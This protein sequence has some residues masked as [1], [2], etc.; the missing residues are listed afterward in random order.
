MT[1]DNLRYLT[2]PNGRRLD[3]ATEEGQLEALRALDH[4]MP[5][6]FGASLE[7]ARAEDP[8]P[9]LVINREEDVCAWFTRADVLGWLGTRADSPVLWDA[10]SDSNRPPGSVFAAFFCRNAVG[11]TQVIPFSWSPENN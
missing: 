3:L 1:D 4:S 5:K 2:L 8:H 7:E 9:V 10:L 6:L 11:W